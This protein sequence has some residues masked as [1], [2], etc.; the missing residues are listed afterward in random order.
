[1]PARVLPFEVKE[2]E[3]ACRVEMTQ[4]RRNTWMSTTAGVL[5]IVSAAIK[6]ALV[7]ALVIAAVVVGDAMT[8]TG[9][10]YWTPVNVTGLLWS[11]AVP[12]AIAG[13][14]SL[15]GG[16]FAL[17]RKQWGWALAGSIA[18]LFPFGLL[19]MV[20]IILTALSKDTFDRP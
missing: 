20:S 14:L 6:F 5:N 17:Q 10:I 8:F 11:V 18:A 2:H 9:V 7:L 19:G 4:T 16:V 12:L 1:M 13:A 15:V 3:E